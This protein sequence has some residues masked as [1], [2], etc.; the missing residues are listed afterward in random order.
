MRNGWVGVVIYGAIRDTEALAQIDFG[1][2]ALGS[3]PARANLDEHGD[4]Q[5][6]LEVGHATV[7][8]GETVTADQDGVIVT[9]AFAILENLH[10]GL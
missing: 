4:S 3:S 10:S 5:I 2:F 1:V 7:L 9:S 8:P 6:A